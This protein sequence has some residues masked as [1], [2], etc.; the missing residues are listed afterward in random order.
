MALTTNSASQIF[1]LYL[2]AMVSTLAMFV[3]G[4]ARK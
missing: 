3:I 2:A 4:F 1:G